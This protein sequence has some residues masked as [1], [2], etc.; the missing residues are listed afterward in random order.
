MVHPLPKWLQL[1]YASLWKKF[2]DEEFTF[3]QIKK[4][5]DDS[6]ETLNVILS[7]MKKAGIIKVSIDSEDGRKRLYKLISPDEMIKNL[8]KAEMPKK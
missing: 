6:D 2:E 4:V 1:R 8:E 5:L 3:E 7:D